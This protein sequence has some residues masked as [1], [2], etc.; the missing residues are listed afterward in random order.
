MT[1]Y[2]CYVTYSFDIQ[3]CRTGILI[4]LYG[5]IVDVLRNIVFSFTNGVGS[6]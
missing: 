3:D 5:G 1:L 4:V 6:Q 2:D